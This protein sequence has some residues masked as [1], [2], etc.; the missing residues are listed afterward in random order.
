MFN[1]I[2][3]EMSFKIHFIPLVCTLN[4]CKMMQNNENKKKSNDTTRIY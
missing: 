4:E 2:N 3:D 1:V